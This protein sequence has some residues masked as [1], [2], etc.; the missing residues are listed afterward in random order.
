MSKIKQAQGWERDYSQVDN[1]R[2]SMSLFCL[3]HSFIYLSYF[4]LSW[5]TG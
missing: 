1:Y 4:C 5:E 2:V 3:S